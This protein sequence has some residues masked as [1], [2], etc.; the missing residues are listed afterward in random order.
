MEWRADLGHDNEGALDEGELDGRAGA[1]DP[2]A[3]VLVENEEVVE[4]VHGSR[5]REGGRQSDLVSAGRGGAHRANVVIV[6][7]GRRWVLWATGR[8]RRGLEVELHL[9]LH[10][11][12]DPD[13]RLHL[14][15]EEGRE[16]DGDG[17]G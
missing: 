2:V 11:H 14:W 6:G 4:E 17:H 15:G 13:A 3:L 8:G 10:L 7:V 1:L 12:L 5:R 16:R 9:H